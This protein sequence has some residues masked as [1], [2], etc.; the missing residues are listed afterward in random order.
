M[1]EPGLDLDLPSTLVFCNI[2][3][4]PEIS[5]MKYLCVSTSSNAILRPSF[6]RAPGQWA[7]AGCLNLHSL[8][9]GA[10]GVCALAGFLSVLH[11]ALYC[12]P[13]QCSWA[14][15][16]WMGDWGGRCLSHFVGSVPQKW[17]N[18]EA[19]EVWGQSVWAL[20]TDCLVLPGCGTWLSS[21][22]IRRSSVFSFV[23]SVTRMPTSQDCCEGCWLNSQKA[24]SLAHCLQMV[25]YC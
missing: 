12:W 2:C 19:W 18:Q 4:V 22:P 25:A 23:R 20:R 10:Y 14:V 7:L 9:S 21:L 1:P 13:P 5:H 6:R 3:G 24:K 17:D 11:R 16:V 15:V 8:F